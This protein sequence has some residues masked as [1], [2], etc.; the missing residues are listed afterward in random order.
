MILGL[1]NAIV[2]RNE[3]PGSAMQSLDSRFPGPKIHMQGFMLALQEDEPCGGSAAWV[4]GNDGSATVRA[5]AAARTAFGSGGDW[6]KN[7][8]AKHIAL[9]RSRSLVYIATSFSCPN[10]RL[11]ATARLGVAWPL[12]GCNEIARSAR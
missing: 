4:A 3:I 9:S 11:P 8:A 2:F 12:T 10:A 7:V 6:N 5:V 1:C